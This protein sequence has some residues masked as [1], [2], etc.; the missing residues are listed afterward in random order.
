MRGKSQAAAPDTEET[1]LR[2]FARR[3]EITVDEAVRVLSSLGVVRE[4]AA[5]PPI[6]RARRQPK[7]AAA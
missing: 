7:D 4:G 1:A 5:S 2:A 6:K 3:N